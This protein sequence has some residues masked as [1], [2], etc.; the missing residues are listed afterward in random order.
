MS[1]KN[2][3]VSLPPSTQLKSPTQ[4]EKHKQCL[5]RRS[6]QPSRRPQPGTSLQPPWCRK[7]MNETLLSVYMSLYACVCVAHTL[8]S[9]GNLPRV[10]AQRPERPCFSSQQTRVSPPQGQT[11]H[12]RWLNL[13]RIVIISL[14]WVIAL[15]GFVHFFH[16]VLYW[17]VHILLSLSVRARPSI[18]RWYISA[19]SA[20]LSGI[21]LMP[22]VLNW[23]CHRII[24]HMFVCFLTRW[25]GAK[26][27][28]FIPCFC[29]LPPGTNMLQRTHSVCCFHVW[30][31]GAGRMK[32]HY[33]SVGTCAARTVNLCNDKLHIWLHK[34][35]ISKI[36]K[37]EILHRPSWCFPATAN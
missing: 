8:P 15:S 1:V 29:T 6:H 2:K 13:R 23:L 34:T 27:Q 26:R 36:L 22:W 16:S 28:R 19:C 20:G 33:L 31:R 30:R 17:C 18:M 24:G 11:S 7:Q 5:E 12:S 9:A 4:N 14:S 21:S 3:A 25:N 10:W 37:I 35:K 32:S